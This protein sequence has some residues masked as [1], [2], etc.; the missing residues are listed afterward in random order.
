[1]NYRFRFQAALLAAVAA[2]ACANA[3][4]ADPGGAPDD[5]ALAASGAA[6]GGGPPCPDVDADGVC[7]DA[8]DLCPGSTIPE[9][10]L[11]N[12]LK[13]H[14]HALVDGDVVFDAKAPAGGVE[15]SKFTLEDTRG[16]T[17]EQIMDLLDVGPADRAGGCSEGMMR[18]IARAGCSTPAC[19]KP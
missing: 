1:M 5:A 12:A 16:C 9:G 2:S 19:E 11:A 14:H 10:F 4:D 17:C 13:T 7:D 6:L 3:P 15:A 8:D 18:L